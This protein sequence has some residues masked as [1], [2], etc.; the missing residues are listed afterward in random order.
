MR[1]SM[2]LAACVLSAA[3]AGLVSIQPAR[4]DL[5]IINGRVIT[6]SGDPA[7][8]ADVGIRAGRIAGVGR[9]TDAPAARTIDAAGRVVA[10]GF[11]DAH[12]H[13]AESI[14]HPDLR[15]ARPLV[16]QG[17]TTIVV[18]P[19]GGGPVDLE[20]QRAELEAA[21]TGVNVALLI[22][23]GAIRT[24]CSA[25]ARQRRTIGSSPVCG[26]LVRNATRDGAYG[27]SSGLFY[28]PGAYAKTEEVIALARIAEAAEC[29]RATS[30]TKADY[31]VG[32]VSAVE[33]VIRIAEE[34]RLTGIVSHMKALGPASW[35]CRPR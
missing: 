17:V 8:S 12:S 31:N 5:L 22:G 14:T 1:R 34:G 29:T 6:G 2:L 20:K 3:S 27:L 32:V 26:T 35:G 28:L 16:A 19:D 23:H 9:L 18:N 25:T 24:R 33:E 7:A 15:Q 11:I 10:P 21:G 4:F 13:A 30:A